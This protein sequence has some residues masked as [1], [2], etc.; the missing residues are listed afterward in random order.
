MYPY[1]PRKEFIN[2]MYIK[3]LPGWKN[4]PMPQ[5]EGGNWENPPNKPTDKYLQAH[6]KIKFSM[7]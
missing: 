2:N 1:L 7:E 3:P 5:V 6:R 4:P